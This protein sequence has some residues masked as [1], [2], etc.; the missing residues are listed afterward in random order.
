MMAFD[1]AL[2]AF[3][4]CPQCRGRLHRIPRRF[5]DRL[6]GL[7]VRSGRYR[8]LAYP[9]G[10]EGR[11][12]CLDTAPYGIVSPPSPGAQVPEPSGVEPPHDGPPPARD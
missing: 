1:P 9:C 12:R 7:F 8:C 2:P 10:W 5:I 3:S 11:L 6:L 4:V